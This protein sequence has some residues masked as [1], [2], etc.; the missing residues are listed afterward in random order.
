M[1]VLQKR[2]KIHRLQ[3]CEHP[4]E[5]VNQSRQDILTKTQRQLRRLSEKSEKSYQARQI[6]GPAAFYNVSNSNIE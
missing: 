5:A 1:S 2:G 4:A 3:G 6:Y